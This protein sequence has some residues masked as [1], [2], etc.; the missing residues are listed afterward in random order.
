MNKFSAVITGI[1][2]SDSLC[3][4]ELDA[5][6]ITLSM[7]LFDLAPSFQQGKRVHVLF[8]ESEVALGKHLRGEIS[9]S[10]RFRAVV[11]A[12]RQGDILSDIT[13]DSKAGEFGSIIT[14]R[15]VE[16]LGLQVSDE[17]TVMFKASQLS[18]ETSHDT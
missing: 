3:C 2:R 9:L 5:S 15:A 8:K 4:I 10:N 13:L 1:Q 14:T 18:L 16:R 7:L 6:G 12:I 17:V 11:R